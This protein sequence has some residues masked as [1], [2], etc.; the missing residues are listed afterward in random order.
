M[1]GANQTGK[2]PSTPERQLDNGCGNWVQVSKQS[3]KGA[4]GIRPTAYSVLISLRL[5]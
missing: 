5:Q 4:V 1:V 2:E 3:F